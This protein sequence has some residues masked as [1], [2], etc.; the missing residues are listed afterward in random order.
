MKNKNVL[1]PMTIEEV[2]SDYKE[3]KLSTENRVRVSVE[4]ICD[5]YNYPI[6]AFV[7]SDGNLIKTERDGHGGFEDTVFRV[8][9]PEDKMINKVICK[10]KEYKHGN[11]NY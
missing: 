6:G 5:V 8:A 9:T 2:V 1:G 11:P 3:I 10:L 4:T 7:T